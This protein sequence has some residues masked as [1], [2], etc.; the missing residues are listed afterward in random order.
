MRSE[1]SRFSRR[2]TAIDHTVIGDLSPTVAAMFSFIKTRRPTR[3][4]S[5][6]EVSAV[7]KAV[8]KVEPRQMLAGNIVASL[9]NGRLKVVGD[10]AANELTITI[11]VNGAVSFDSPNTTVNGQPAGDVEL[12]GIVDAIAAAMHDGNDTL[13]I[14]GEGS[15]NM[16]P[17]IER[18]VTVRMGDGWDDLTIRGIAV[19]GRIYA[20][21]GRHS[22]HISIEGSSVTGNVILAG[23]HSRDT[24]AARRVDVQGHLILRGG[25]GRDTMVEGDNL[26]VDGDIR[27]RGGGGNNT[28]VDTETSDDLDAYFEQ[29]GSGFGLDRLYG[30]AYNGSVDEA[31]NEAEFAAGFPDFDLAEFTE[32]PSGLQYRIID[33][34]SSSHPTVSDSV[35]VNYQGLNAAG[36]EFDSSFARGEPISFPLNQL[37]VG[38]QE[39]IPLVGE[40]GKI[41]LLIPSDLAY[42]ANGSGSAIAPYAALLFN[43]E[44]ILID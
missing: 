39:G 19:G 10:D 11:D 34:G 4:R 29:S 13:T 12:D 43:I 15:L 6:A 41:Q 1:Q 20:A 37:I 3:V 22:D 18:N 32:L 9:E 42:G 40:G 7:E 44:L 38:W 8:E 5:S 35:T 30:W 25:G 31:F 36:T 14:E 17:S 16:L 21:G 33:P 2:I 27:V 28:N 23:N 24:L 26:F